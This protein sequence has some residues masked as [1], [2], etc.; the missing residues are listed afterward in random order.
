MTNS[1]APSI[2]AIKRG[3]RITAEILLGRGHFLSN[4]TLREQELAN[5]AWKLKLEKLEFPGVIS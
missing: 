1:D 4:L 3:T 5:N 2:S